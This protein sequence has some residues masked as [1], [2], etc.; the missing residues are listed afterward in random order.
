MLN[1]ENYTLKQLQYQYSE[2]YKKQIVSLAAQLA[3]FEMYGLLDKSEE[4]FDFLIENIGLNF[5]F[6]NFSLIS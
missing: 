4:I 5:Y 6:E 2:E 3:Y 1:L